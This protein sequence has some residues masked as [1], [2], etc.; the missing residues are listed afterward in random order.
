MKHISL[1]IFILV[2]IAGIVGI[3]GVG[4]L[5]SDIDLLSGN[6]RVIIDEHSEN[7]NTTNEIRLLLYKHQTVVT[8]HVMADTEQ[9]YIEYKAQANE[10]S[11]KL[12]D[13]FTDFGDKMSGGIREQLFH[14]AYTE[15]CSYIDDSK[16]AMQL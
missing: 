14:A 6:Y 7:I 16:N 1:K 11:S 15:F 12:M 4:I 13:I 2:L 8:K 5:K 10:L 3:A 9:K